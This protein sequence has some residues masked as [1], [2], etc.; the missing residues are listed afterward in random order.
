MTAHEALWLIKTQL[1]KTD[2]NLKAVQVIQELVKTYTLDE[3]IIELG[4]GNELEHIK[5]HMAKVGKEDIEEYSKSLTDFA[6]FAEEDD[7]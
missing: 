3:T 5:N 4:L 2:Q 6:E 7:D 1:A